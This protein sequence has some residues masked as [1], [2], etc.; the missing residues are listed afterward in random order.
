MYYKKLIVA[1]LKKLRIDSILSSREYLTINN[2]NKPVV[3]VD[4]V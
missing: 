2:I 4:N 3:H 1:E